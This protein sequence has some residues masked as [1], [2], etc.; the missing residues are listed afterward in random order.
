MKR[1]LV[2]GAEGQL[3]KCIQKIAETHRHLQFVFL[4]ADHLDITDPE[5]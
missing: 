4:D 2:T 5:R 3:G 1:V